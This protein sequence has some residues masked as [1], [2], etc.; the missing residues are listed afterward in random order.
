VALPVNDRNSRQTANEFANQPNRPVLRAERQTRKRPCRAVTGGISKVD[1]R[2]GALT[3][4]NQRW[5]SFRDHTP[6]GCGQPREERCEDPYRRSCARDPPR[7]LHRRGSDPRWDPQRRFWVVL[8]TGRIAAR[9]T[10]P[11]AATRHG[12]R[13]RDVAPAPTW[14]MEPARTGVPDP[15]RARRRTRRMGLRDHRD[16]LPRVTRAGRVASSPSGACVA[17]G[18]AAGEGSAHPCSPCC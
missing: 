12:R 10:R 7:S 1:G 6:P 3:V 2:F 17:G 14:R 8:D 13:K 11:D 9:A 5:E 15:C 18:F 4:I 16:L